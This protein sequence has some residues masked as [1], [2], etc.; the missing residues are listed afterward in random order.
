[1]KR[2]N[3]WPSFLI[4]VSVVVL[5]VAGTAEESDGLPAF[6]RKLNMSC[7]TCHSA[8]PLLNAFGRAYKTNGYR[9]MAA[10]EQ[11]GT[12]EIQPEGRLI[13]EEHFPWSALIKMQPYDK[14]R[15]EDTK[16]R[17]IHEMEFLAAGTASRE[18]TYF[19]EIEAEDEEDFELRLGHVI[20]QFQ[21]RAE[22]GVHLATNTGIFHADPYNALS[23]HR[24]TRAQKLPLVAGFASDE[25]LLG[26]TQQVIFTGRSDRF[27][28]L[29]GIGTG[30]DDPEGEGRLDYAGRVALDVVPAAVAEVANNNLSVRISRKMQFEVALLLVIVM[31]LSYLLY[32]FVM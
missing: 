6:A 24:I 13:L 26:G 30:S 29:A 3:R 5:L 8:Y 1:M 18:V 25:A 23:A 7:N 17:A 16:V 32:N 31:L 20:V 15:D 12:G 27:F 22:Y 2:A 11:A 10:H 4:L 9:L 28:Y 14:K 21:P 19:F